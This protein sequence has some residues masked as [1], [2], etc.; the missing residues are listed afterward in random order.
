MLALLARRHEVVALHDQDEVD[1]ARLPCPALRVSAFATQ[2]SPFDA[3][4]YQL[5][6]GPGHDF[7]YQWLTRAPGLLVL[8]DLV[9]HHA[10]ARMFLAA[11]AAR[12]YAA[13]PHSAERR[14]AISPASVS[15]F[16]AVTDTVP[17]EI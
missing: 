4:V 14:T 7:V 16:S 10:R 12:A 6:N 1:R 8:H 17:C 5:G 13:A 2:S 9:L 11:P 3:F 15:S